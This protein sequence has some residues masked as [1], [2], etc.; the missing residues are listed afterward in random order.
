MQ[1]GRKEKGSIM[2]K[3]T[4]GQTRDKMRRLE[5]DNERLNKTVKDQAQI[6]RKLKAEIAANEKPD[7]GADID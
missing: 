2:T 3:L 6:I 7:A 5:R 1:G 4:R